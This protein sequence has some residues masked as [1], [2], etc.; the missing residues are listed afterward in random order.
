VATVV[1][2]IAVVAATGLA[3]VALRKQ[4]RDEQARRRAVD[5]R[6]SAQAYQAR[7]TLRSWLEDPTRPPGGPSAFATAH[8]ANFVAEVSRHF[9]AVEARL[10]Q[11][12]GDAPSASPEVAVNVRAAF[13]V[14]GR[15]TAQVYREIQ[16]AAKLGERTDQVFTDA[17]RDFEVCAELLTAA[18]DPELRNA[19][20]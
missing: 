11:M 20:I 6:I 12:A 18:I 2:A 16:R 15:A 14:F 17:M 9:P 19:K 3:Y 8:E 5:G 1:E 10:E 4:D 13:V 7:R